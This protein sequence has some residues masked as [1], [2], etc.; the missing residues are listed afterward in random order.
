MKDFEIWKSNL[1]NSTKNKF[2][3]FDSLNHLFMSGEGK[4]TPSE[5][6]IQ[7]NV[8]EEVIRELSDWIKA[9]F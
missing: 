8:D 5:Y 6:Q 2:V 7:G 1:G 4:S 3:V 9:S